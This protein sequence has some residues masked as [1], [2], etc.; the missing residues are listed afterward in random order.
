MKPAQTIAVALFVLIGCSRTRGDADDA[1][2]TRL[3][4]HRAQQIERLHAYAV[5][6]QFPHN[7]TS[8]TPVH[9]FRDADGRYCAV[10]NLVHQ[11]GRDDLVAATVRENN[12]LA[13]HDVHGGQMMDWIVESGLTQDELE[14][15][16]FP[17]KPLAIL[18]APPIFAPPKQPS[19]VDEVAAK[20]SRP[21][22]RATVDAR[23]ED[24]M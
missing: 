16:Q 12:D 8:P 22:P 19:P 24:A 2:R 11:D 14:R 5:A 1:L 7:T 15:I 10:A 23:D 20:A 21:L 6:G 18:D 9:I 4:A 3:A 17:S 13:V